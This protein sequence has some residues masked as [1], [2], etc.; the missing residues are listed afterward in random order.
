MN[1]KLLL[2]PILWISGCMLAT[3][4]VVDFTGTFQPAMYSDSDTRDGVQLAS[5][6]GTVTI[7][8]G[9]SAN[10]LDLSLS[11]NALSMSLPLVVND[12]VATLAGGS[13][14]V[15]TTTVRDTY[16]LSD[17]D[18]MTLAYVA[19]DQA[20]A[21]SYIVSAWQRNPSFADA[22]T[23]VGQWV[24]SPAFGD[25]NLRDLTNGFRPQSGGFTINNTGSGYALV[26]AEMNVI[27]PLAISQGNFTL[28]SAPAP[29]GSGAWQV[30]G[31]TYGQGLG[32]LFFVGT[33]LNDE[34]DVSITLGLIR[35]TVPEPETYTLVLAGLGVLGGVMARR[36]KHVVGL[37]IKGAT[38]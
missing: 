35:Q 37:K 34:T 20:G 36:R 38:H 4:A 25:P 6:L 2:I 30:L 18:N 19:Q 8:A 7:G 13:Y 31:G 28:T 14:T 11:F 15:G 16:L 5:G 24:F 32:A 12:N 33:E 29:A 23:A 9:T 1:S 27:V 17:G 22:S 10:Q 26:V 3:A 21:I